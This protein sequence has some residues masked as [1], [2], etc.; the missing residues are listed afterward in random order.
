[1]TVGEKN[2]SGRR[3]YGCVLEGREGGGICGKQ[4]QLSSQIISSGPYNFVGHF[5]MIVRIQCILTHVR[6]HACACVVSIGD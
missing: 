1:M 4:L 5:D 3:I 2:I 6:R